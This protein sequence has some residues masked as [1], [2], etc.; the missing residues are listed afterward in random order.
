MEVLHLSLSLVGV[1]R[2][3]VDAVI[4]PVQKGEM[5]GMKE[6]GGTSLSTFG[7]RAFSLQEREWENDGEGFFSLLRTTTIV[8]G[9]LIRR[10]GKRG[11]GKWGI[12][13]GWGHAA[14]ADAKHFIA[15]LSVV[16]SWKNELG[17]SE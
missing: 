13:V 15:S 8:T 7:D 11:K 4:A 6:G 3:P 12:G 2:D 10:L 1:A 16:I 17:R 9:V 14:Q 5:G